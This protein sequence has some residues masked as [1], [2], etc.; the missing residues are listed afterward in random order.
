[1]LREDRLDAVAAI[2]VTTD[3]NKHYI[4]MPAETATVTS[5]G[6]CHSRS[7]LG[8]MV[9]WTLLSGTFINGGT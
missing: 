7:V 5:T 2:V 1:M 8:I 4:T 6:D 9:R 3:C